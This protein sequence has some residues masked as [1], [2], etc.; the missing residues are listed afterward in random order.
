MSTPSKKKRKNQSASQQ[1]EPSTS[2]SIIDATARDECP[3]GIALE[4]GKVLY[5]EGKAQISVTRGAIWLNGTFL[6]AGSAKTAICADTV[7]GGALPIE[8]VPSGTQVPHPHQDVQITFHPP[9]EPGASTTASNTNGGSSA[10]DRWWVLP[11]GARAAPHIPQDWREAAAG[12][13]A[14]IAEVCAAGRSGGRAVAVAGAKGTGKSSF[15]RLLANSLLNHV[16]RVAWLDADCGQPEFT[17][18]GLVSLTY[19]DCPIYGL[20]HMHQRAPAQA[21]FVGQLS[22]ERDPIAYKGAVEEL[23]TWHAAHHAS[24]PLIINT[25]GWIKGLGLD[26][27]ADLLQ[28]A[29]PSHVVLLQT[30]NVRRNLPAEPFWAA[31][32]GPGQVPAPASTILLLQAVGQLHS[33]EAA[34]TA[35]K[36][37][38]T[39]AA[40]K[41]LTAAETRSLSWLV[42]AHDLLRLPTSGVRWEAETLAAAARGL[43]AH[44]P[45][46]VRLSDVAVEVLHVSLPPNQLGYVL[47]GA[48]VG[49]CSRPH[50]ADTDSL[51]STGQGDTVCMGVGIVRAVDIA[52]CRAYVLAPL[53]LSSMQKINVLQVGRLE[54]PPE[55][56]QSGP[57]VSPY[58]ST[59]SIGTAGTGAGAIKSR[60][61]LVRAAQLIT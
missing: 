49:L 59:W 6:E 32:A 30:A 45:Y 35:Q 3:S 25:C 14:A 34:A 2:K 39:P 61:N 21:R 37:P 8:A 7:L 44:T 12:V 48:L 38:G 42:W 17:V 53:D 54:L 27:L 9:V 46:S 24:T 31:R 26:L 50:R 13:S 16:Q 10:G 11:D 4:A 52:Q 22:P 36:L 18:P 60:N 20:P 29:R 5:F 55:L 57:V 40:P 58:L 1:S 33:D 15:A 23:L 19:V 43:A 28:T 41:K 47:N 51:Q 56:L